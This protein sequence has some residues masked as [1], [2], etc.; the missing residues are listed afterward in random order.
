MPLEK[1]NLYK[2]KILDSNENKTTFSKLFGPLAEAIQ[3]GSN[4]CV[5]GPKPNIENYLV[6]ANDGNTYLNGNLMRNQMTGMLYYLQS[7]GWEE[8]DFS[9]SGAARTFFCKA[10]YWFSTY[11]NH[12]S[13][14]GE[15]IVPDVKLD[16]VPQFVIPYEY[17]PEKL[18]R[19]MNRKS[20]LL[21]S[22]IKKK[23]MAR[24]GVAVA[25]S[26][27][28]QHDQSNILWRISIS[29]MDIFKNSKVCDNQILDVL[30]I[31]KD[32][33][34]V[35]LSRFSKNMFS[36]YHIKI[37]LLWCLEERSILSKQQLLDLTLEKLS[38]SYEQ[39]FL[40]D[41]F[42]ETCN[43][44]GHVKKEIATEIYTSIKSVRKN[45]HY[46]LTECQLKQAAL[47]L[48]F[49]EKISHFSLLG[50]YFLRLV[51][52]LTKTYPSII[53]YI[54][55]KFWIRQLEQHGWQND[56]LVSPGLLDRMK[57]D[58]QSNILCNKMISSVFDLTL[59]LIKSR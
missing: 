9:E 5:F 46:W 33:R 35:A 19:W 10:S 42:D 47:R 28:E 27:H 50:T 55:W 52:V 51:L 20:K 45:I 56:E 18:R 32:L 25:K 21:D 16:Y 3:T 12:L 43:L 6:E 2:L 34:I 38:S 13:K 14:F 37:A 1:S 49:S 59:D 31:L 57:K 17:L 4:P 40:P 26:L 30:V 7:N 36:S 39:I 58:K 23:I 29:P 44:I 8:I 15:C 22:S 24:G 41:Y 54:L 48:S 11:Q 53:K